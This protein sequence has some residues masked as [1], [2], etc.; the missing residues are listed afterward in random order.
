MGF[1]ARRRGVGMVIGGIHPLAIAGEMLTT[2]VKTHGAH[3]LEDGHR[4]TNRR[5]PRAPPMPRAMSLRFR[6]G[7][8]RFNKQATASLVTGTFENCI[9][10][11]RR[12]TV[13]IPR[14]I[15]SR[16]VT[17]AGQETLGT[18]AAATDPQLDDHLLIFIIPLDARLR[19][20]V[21]GDVK[22][23]RLRLAVAIIS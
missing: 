19:L 23:V 14:I 2:S 5:G 9:F 12:L 13:F 20:F 6:S 8:W 17:R 7:Q 18:L 22:K 3:H 11:V 15:F 21:I 16:R 4:S 1:H 10:Y